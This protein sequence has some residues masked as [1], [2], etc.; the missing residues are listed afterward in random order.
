MK[1]SI[2]ADFEA[3]RHPS[4]NNNNNNNN[5]SNDRYRQNMGMN[6]GYYQQETYENVVNGKK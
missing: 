4:G 2:P 1:I 6:D 5:R 3:R